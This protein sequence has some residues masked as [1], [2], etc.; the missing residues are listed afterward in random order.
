VRSLLELER[1]IAP[2]P[3]STRDRFIMRARAA[4]VALGDIRPPP[5]RTVRLFPWV[6][7]VVG[8]VCLGSAAGGFAAYR[9]C[10]RR[11]ELAVRAERPAHPR[12]PAPEASAAGTTAAEVLPQALLLGIPVQATDAR[13]AE[14]MGLLEQA[15]VAVS[16][17]DFAGALGPLAA[18]ARRFKHG[19]LAEE[20]EALRIRALAGLGRRDELR[21]AA[22]DFR[23]H[24]PRSLLV[25]IVNDLASSGG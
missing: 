11:P 3:D 6:A 9:W 2:L 1:Q 5:R 4:L 18:H 16:R 22:A 23:V 15:R 14:E 24:F 19:R 13:Q 25:P 21:R 10:F 7:A 20:R 17:D 12:L 8:M